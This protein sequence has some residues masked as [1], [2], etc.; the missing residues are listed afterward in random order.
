VHSK[1]SIEVN[2]DLEQSKEKSFE[3]RQELINAAIN[4][5]S[6]KGYDNASLNNILKGTGISKGTF[7]YH[8][9]NKEDLYFYLVSL[10]VEEKIKFLN[11]KINPE[12]F[13]TDFFSLLQILIEAGLDFARRNPMI[14]KFLQRY[15]KEHGSAINE[16]VAKKFNFK[17]NEYM[18]HL[19]DS[20][21]EKGNFRK[22]LPI[23]FIKRTVGYLF[24]HIQDV[25]DIDKVEDYEAAAENLIEFLKSGLVRQ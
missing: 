23:S 3:K 10:L 25:A 18:D 9:A 15:I 22:D 5:F 13:N 19:I 17:S 16:K 2:R 11:E 21:Y 20:A 4:E 1:I 14:D 24:T 8:F 12:D 6:D 7:Y